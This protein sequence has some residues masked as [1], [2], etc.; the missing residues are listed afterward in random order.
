MV[1][2]FNTASRGR[3]G[4][5][6]R[7]SKTNKWVWVGKCLGSRGKGLDRMHGIPVVPA[8]QQGKADGQ[9]AKPCLKTNTKAASETL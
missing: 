8:A 1:Q 6:V 4:D 5:T 2:T 3:Q 7:L 9:P